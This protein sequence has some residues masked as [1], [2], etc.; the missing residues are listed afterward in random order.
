VAG[1]RLDNNT[2]LTTQSERRWF[3][4]AKNIEQ[5]HEDDEG[6]TEKLAKLWLECDSTTTQQARQSERRY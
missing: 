5:H 3:L 4:D 1:V 6:Y 2:G